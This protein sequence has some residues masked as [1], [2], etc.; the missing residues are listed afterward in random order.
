MKTKTTVTILTALAAISLAASG[1][2]P[3][4]VKSRINQVTVFL[5]GAQV[6]RSASI[7]VPA[8][9]STL[10][11][12]K[13]PQSLSPQ[14]LQVS[15]TGS[16]TIL[17]VS[18]QYNYLEDREKS[19]QVTSLEKKLKDLQKQL[20]LQE[21]MRK[22]Y[23]S[24]EAMLL[25]NK[26]VGGTEAGLVLQKLKEAAD[27]FRLRLTEIS[28]KKLEVQE[29][30]QALNEEIQN[31]RNQLSQAGA[32]GRIHVSEVLVQITSTVAQ[33]ISLEMG[34]FVSNAGWTPSYDIRATDISHPLEMHYKAG[35]YQNT[36]E[37]WSRVKLALSTGN[38]QLSGTKP[39]L[40]PWYLN[41]F[42]P[43]YPVSSMQKRSAGA[44][45]SK[46]MAMEEESAADIM[47]MAS[48]AADFS[49]VTEGQTQVVFG[50]SI[51]YTIASGG[52]PQGVEIQRISLPAVYEYHA[53]P[54][55]D[56]DAFLQARITGWEAYNLL[57]GEM[58]LFFEGTFVGRAWLD[59]RNTTDTLSLS[60][61]RDKKIL[62]ERKMLKEFTRKQL[63]GNKRTETRHWEIQVRNNKSE[64]VRLVIM[65]QFPVSV[66]KEIEVSLSETSGAQVNQSKGFLTW[67]LDLK[68]GS[69]EKITAGYEVK[70]PE[71]RNVALE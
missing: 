24:E 67:K 5:Q 30:I 8:G 55:L 33:A 16:F 61:G 10:V 36:G 14:S 58:N 7:K 70:Y 31:V 57:P 54:R 4:P 20:A 46:S 40:Q 23:E 60:L 2:E 62:I 38:P 52:K 64:P 45:M 21:A 13:L 37:D 39:D 53:V 56:P 28:A 47:E 25:A 22:V 18:H 27:F 51:P 6:N 42:Q 19:D 15:G 68:P 35:V 63:L 44:P 66:N 1:N 3:L 48:S 71:G 59:V 65:D 32:V 9:T 49:S 69:T 43:V 17:S 50:I 41:F 11:F 29:K 26:T 34:Y 12:E